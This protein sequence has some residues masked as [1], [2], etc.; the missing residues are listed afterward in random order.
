[1]ILVD[2]NLLCN[3]LRDTS[4]NEPDEALPSDRDLRFRLVTIVP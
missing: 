4:P 2:A 3:P 1:M